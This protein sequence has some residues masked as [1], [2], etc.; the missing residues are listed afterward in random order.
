M[1]DEARLNLQ[2]GVPE[3][4]F[5]PAT[6]YNIESDLDRWVW[7]HVKIMNQ[8]KEQDRKRE[9]EKAL[10][11]YIEQEIGAILEKKLDELLEGFKTL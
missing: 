11:D 8:V 9:Q 4:P 1:T 5:Y 10:E 2:R 3:N 6:T 7:Q